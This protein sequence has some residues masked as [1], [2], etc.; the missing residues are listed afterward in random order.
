[1]LCVYSHPQPTHACLP[2]GANQL[3]VLPPE[4]CLL[5]NLEDLNIA[6]NRLQYV[7]S[8]LLTMSLR[9][10]NLHPNPFLPPPNFDDRPVSATETVIPGRVI[11]LTEM[12]YR[13]LIAPAP[14]TLFSKGN[15]DSFLSSHYDL[16]LPPTC[17]LPPR[18]TETLNACIPGSVCL[19][20]PM[21]EIRDDI[22]MGI[23][24]NPDHQAAGC[25]FVRPAE[26]RLSWERTIAGQN[27][28]GM[29]PVLWR[30]CEYGCLDFLKPEVEQGQLE[31]ED[32]DMAVDEV[33][34]VREIELRGFDDLDFD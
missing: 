23:C 19:S 29:V 3:T 27:T 4:I 2:V 24:G 21:S 11:P 12:L 8:E 16:P 1:M 13:V 33:N 28:G 34:V 14:S 25:L 9:V 18:V 6:N 30:G 15:P 31:T 10:L 26:Q 17:L 22:S 32:I 5:R 7:P 20:D